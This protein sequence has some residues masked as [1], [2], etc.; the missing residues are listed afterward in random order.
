MKV[1]NNSCNQG[2]PVSGSYFGIIE[3]VAPFTNTIVF[4]LDKALTV[5]TQYSITLSYKVPAN[6]TT[7]SATLRYGYGKD[8]LS[9][10]SISGY[11]PVPITTTTWKKDTLKFIPKQVWQHVWVELGTLGGDPFELHID[12]LNM[13]GIAPVQPPSSSVKEVVAIPV[14]TLAPNPFNNSTTLTIDKKLAKPYMIQVF[15]VTGR[16]VIQQDKLDN[17]QFIINRG[18]LQTGV[19]IEADRP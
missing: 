7:M 14:M 8:S 6:A 10:D 11:K 15:D 18:T 1:A 5:N 13:L 4:K 9:S 19:Y 12:D 3:Y 17:N 2:N 16:I